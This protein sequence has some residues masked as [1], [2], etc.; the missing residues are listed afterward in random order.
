MSRETPDI[1][2]PERSNL[3]IGEANYYQTSNAVMVVDGHE[4]RDTTRTHP[5]MRSSSYQGGSKRGFGSPVS[6]KKSKVI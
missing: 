5:M 2:D 3:G 1:D 6:T 4:Q